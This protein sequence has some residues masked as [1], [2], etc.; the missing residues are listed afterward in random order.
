MRFYD[1]MMGTFGTIVFVV[2]VWVLRCIYK[3]C[4]KPFLCPPATGRR[5]RLVNL[6]AI[7]REPDMFRR[8]TALRYLS[9]VQRMRDEETNWLKRQVKCAIGAV[10]DRIASHGIP[11]IPREFR[12]RESSPPKDDHV[13]EW[14]K[15]VSDRDYES[16][17]FAADPNYL[18]QN[19][20]P[21]LLK[22]K[23]FTN[24]ASSSGVQ[25][26]PSTSRA[27][28]SDSDGYEMTVPCNP[29][30]VPSKPAD[31]PP[32]LPGADGRPLV[33]LVP[34][35]GKGKGRGKKSPAARNDEGGDTGD[36]EADSG[37][38]GAG[39]GGETVTRLAPA[40]GKK[41]TGR[42]K[43]TS[44]RSAP[45]LP[46]RRSSRQASSAYSHSTVRFSSRKEEAEIVNV[47]HAR[48]SPPPP[49]P[50]QTLRRSTR[51]MTRSTESLPPPPP[52]LLESDDSFTD[53]YR[54]LNQVEENGAA[55]SLMRQS[56]DDDGGTVREGARLTV[57]AASLA[58]EAVEAVEK[59][60]QSRYPRR[61]KTKSR[62]N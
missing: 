41:S 58:P 3:Y 46:P 25:Q 49:S 33:P 17:S 42:K 55:F 28:D 43:I 8:R 15:I 34:Y 2:S 44:P 11:P 16:T 4:V 14:E 56:D 18:F 61:N 62:K 30:P 37:A 12:R 23:K 38:D 57:A 9:R 40:Q 47:L 48:D 32:Q 51:S 60:A 31:T 10:G 6:R 29:A 35:T 52:E 24:G 36:D 13:T 5:R 22:E 53:F 21:L 50:P 27:T 19:T 26:E 7:Q 59:N 45:P 54:T 1:H 39:E 20:V